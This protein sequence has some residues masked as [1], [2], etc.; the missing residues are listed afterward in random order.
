MS[1]RRWFRRQAAL[2]RL[3]RWHAGYLALPRAARKS[4]RVFYRAE[5][6]QLLSAA[7]GAGASARQI[8]DALSVAPPAVLGV[9]DAG[10]TS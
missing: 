1:L 2:A 8:C 4:G 3:A 5:F 9:T 6:D 7:E 10:V